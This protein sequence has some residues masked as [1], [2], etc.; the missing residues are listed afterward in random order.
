MR[1]IARHLLYLIVYGTLGALLA[2]GSVYVLQLTAQPALQPWHRAAFPH[3]F[4]AADAGRIRTLADYL[5]QEQQV[6]EELSAQVYDNPASRTRL[7]FIR[8]VRG[9]LADASRQSPDWNRSFELPVGAPAGGALLLHGLSDSPYSLRAI[10]KR[11]QAHGY[12]VVGLRLP[13]HGTTPSALKGVQWEDFAAAVRIGVR[14]VRS[15]IGEGRPLVIVGYSNGAAL[16]VEYAL[17]RLQG[18]DVPRVDGLVL[19]SPAIG[20]TPAAAFAVWQGRL[21]QLLREEK[22]GW[23]DI[24]PEYD[25]YKYASFPVNAGDQSYRL[26]QRIAQ[27]ISSLAGNAAVSGMPPVLAFQSVADDTV[28]TPAV[29]QGLF[30]RF[31]PGGHALVLFDINRNSDFAAL[32]RVGY[33]SAREELL[34]GP[35]LTFDLTIVSNAADDSQEV[36][37]RERPAGGSE[38]VTRRIDL[39]WPAGVFSLSH[40][41]IPFPPDDPVYGGAPPANRLLIYLGRLDVAGERGVLAVP[42]AQMLRLR[43]NPFFPYVEQRVAA[44]L[45]GLEAAPVSGTQR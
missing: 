31:A 16:A 44:F 14:H 39:Q 38:V 27:Q 1:R 33:T 26:T 30:R 41:A 37:A 19:L 6:F 3:E 15:Q 34:H 12:S 21:G 28:S 23:I 42:P 10:G 35:A 25:P 13:G 43:H 17:S 40:V 32:Y 9:S 18:E 20:V 29:V 22:L 36:V 11:L 2:L 7:P 5:A 45:A 4:H 8:Y 24:Q